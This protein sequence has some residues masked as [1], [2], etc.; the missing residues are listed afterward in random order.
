M[1]VRTEH[2]EM[3]A[4]LEFTCKQPGSLRAQ[5]TDLSVD[6]R[7]GSIIR[8]FLAIKV[9][10][11]GYDQIE[12]GSLFNLLPNIRGRI[13]TCKLDPKVGVELDLKLNPTFIFDLAMSFSSAEEIARHLLKLNREGGASLLQAENWYAQ[14]VKQK[15]V[16]PPEIGEG[17]LKIGYST[18]W[19]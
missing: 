12:S 19:A 16:L 4:G 6:L 2:F 7:G 13:L 10:P 15:V 8:C 3:D 17:Q 9:S 18:S 11:E 1:A 5:A 14:Y